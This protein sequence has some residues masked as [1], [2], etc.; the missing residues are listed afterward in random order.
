MEQLHGQLKDREIQVH[1][2]ADLLVALDFGLIV[3]VL[4]N[5]IDNADK[6]SPP[7]TPIE[8]HART[9]KQ[10][11]EIQVADRGI[12]IPAQ[13]LERVFDR[14]YRVQNPDT[15]RGTGMGLA[16]CKGIIEAHGGEIQAEQRAGGGTVIRF[17]LPRLTLPLSN[18]VVRRV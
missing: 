6:Y 3:Q 15:V 8:I 9:S 16:I 11:L 18:R 1:V 13:D 7:D 12:G 17:T 4:V 5:L 10:V 14:F 2:P